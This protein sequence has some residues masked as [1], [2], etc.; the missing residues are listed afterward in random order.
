MITMCAE[1]K[2]SNY[3][4]PKIPESAIYDSKLRTEGLPNF[5]ASF[6]PI[7]NNNRNSDIKIS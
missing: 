2:G 1:R 4:F 3:G 7:K 5:R 6:A